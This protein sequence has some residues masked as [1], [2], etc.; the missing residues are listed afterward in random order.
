MSL[1]VC[2]SLVCVCTACCPL[3][4]RV[5]R[6]QVGGYT[7]DLYTLFT[8]VAD[9]GGCEAVEAAGAWGEVA[10]HRDWPEGLARTATGEARRGGDMAVL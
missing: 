5:Q 4:V 6:H 1:F 8:L 3:C 2:L 10:K 7:L 9:R